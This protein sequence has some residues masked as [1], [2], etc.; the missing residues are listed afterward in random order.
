MVFNMPVS[1]S[2][3]AE[4]DFAMIISAFFRLTMPGGSQPSPISARRPMETCFIIASDVSNRCCRLTMLLKL[5]RC[6]LIS[7]DFQ[8]T[9]ELAIAATSL[10]APPVFGRRWGVRAKER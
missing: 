9:V 6:K 2:F 8:C 4:M 10:P 3:G 5:A 7:L 1:G